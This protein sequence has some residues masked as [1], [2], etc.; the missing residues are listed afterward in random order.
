M[1]VL[2]NIISKTTTF[3]TKALKAYPSQINDMSSYLAFKPKSLPNF[4]TDGSGKH[5]AQT[6]IICDLPDCETKVCYNPCGEIIAVMNNGH[7]THKPPLGSQT[8]YLD[9]Q[10]FNGKTT[11]NG[12]HFVKPSTKPSM[13]AEDLKNI[14]ENEMEPNKL[15][16][17]YAMMPHI[18]TKIK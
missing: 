10:D 4:A 1:P 17:A 14:T 2:N 11:P 7:Y 16:D 8:E 3:L 18:F 5:V 13:S 6:K 12:Q 9:A 15:A